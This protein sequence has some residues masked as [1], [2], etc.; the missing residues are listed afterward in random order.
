M[1]YKNIFIIAAAALTLVACGKNETVESTIKLAYSPLAYEGEHAVKLNNES[2][3]HY[4]PDK[5]ISISKNSKEIESRTVLTEYLDHRDTENGKVI[6]S[7]NNKNEPILIK[8][9][10]NQLDIKVGEALNFPLEGLC[11]YQPNGGVL[12]VFLMD[13]N[14]IAHQM[15]VKETDDNISLSTLRTFPLPPE[16]EHCVVH[17]DSDQFFVSEDRIGVW[18]YSARAESQVA[19]HVVDL[20]TP[21]GVLTFNSGPLSIIDDTLFIAESG[22]NL[23]HSLQIERHSYI[24]NT[25]FELPKEIQFKNLTASNLNDE[26]DWHFVALDDNSSKLIT[27]SLPKI[28]RTSTNTFISN[29]APTAETDPVTNKGDAAD[30]PAIWINSQQPEN[31]RILGT[32]KKRG[33]YVYDLTGKQLQELLVDRVNNVDVRQGFTLKNIPADIAAASQ[34]DRSSIALF[35]IEPET[36]VVTFT[37]EIS[38]GLDDVYGL[39]MYRGKENRVYVFI[40]DEDGRYEQWEISDSQVGWQ[41]NMVRSFSVESQPEG[42]ATDE[43][44]HRLFVGEENK[45][46]WTLGA[47]PSDDIN[48]ELMAPISDILTADIEGMEVYQTNDR[49]I[50][51]VSSQGNDSFVLFDARPPFNYLGRFRVGLNELLGIDGASETDGLTVT[52][53]NLGP[54]YPKGLLVVQDG[55]NLLPMENQN[56]KMVSWEE[57]EKSLNF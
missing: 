14:N 17:D 43:Q 40:N 23:V 31:S 6:F 19:R 28:E 45:A 10:N 48:M 20:V 21:Y 54:L 56:Y 4:G 22:S 47:E 27:F 8:T 41:G 46:V 1:K 30:D 49:S 11:L 9:K 12:Q 3:I 5:E 2:W 24:R 18:A 53:A 32:N 7:V 29:V 57:I 35:H 13:D 37:N 44:Q 39:C 36:G 25:V 34:R 26:K 51:V 50:L 55:R 33:L 52:S 38:T 42:C 15:L 16:S